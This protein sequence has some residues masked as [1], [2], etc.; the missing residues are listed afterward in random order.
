[1]ETPKIF[2][3]NLLN[4]YADSNRQKLDAALV[5]LRI[6]KQID[7]FLDNYNLNQKDLASGLGVSEAFVSQL[8]SG[9]KKINMQI[10]SNFEKS[11]NA[12][13]DF[14]LK[15]KISAYKSSAYD[16]IQV[17]NSSIELKSLTHEFTSINGFSIINDSNT[18]YSLD[19]EL[20]PIVITK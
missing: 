12:E 13:F 6:V 5:S 10:L 2:D 20:N 3:N 15:R 19:T 9:S 1:M 14:T 7:D 18:V 8:M 4:S 17:V 11:F 16:V